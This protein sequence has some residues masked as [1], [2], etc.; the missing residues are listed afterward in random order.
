[1]I[2]RCV[3]LNVY[4]EICVS[5]CVYAVS[6]CLSLSLSFFFR[7]KL[8]EFCPAF[9]SPYFQYRSFEVFLKVV[10][11]SSL[12]S[13]FHRLLSLSVTHMH[14]SMHI[15]V[16]VCVHCKSRVHGVYVGIFIGIYMDMY[17]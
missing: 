5:M 2:R 4:V 10:E 7:E 17:T 16:R 12:I 13:S 11:T 8:S 1:M 9:A 6:L 14:T 3:H 15:Y